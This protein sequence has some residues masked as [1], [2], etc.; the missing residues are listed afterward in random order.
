MTSVAR[1]LLLFGADSS[2]RAAGFAIADLCAKQKGFP[3]L[4][5]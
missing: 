5:K 1:I 2:C 4:I 3:E